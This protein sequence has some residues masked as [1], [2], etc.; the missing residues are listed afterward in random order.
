MFAPV[1]LYKFSA[2]AGR[3]W[4]RTNLSAPVDFESHTYAPSPIARQALVADGGEISPLFEVTLP[5]DD[6]LVQQ[7]LVYLPL[8]PL[9]LV[10]YRREQAEGPFIPVFIGSVASTNFDDGDATLACRPFGESLLLKVPSQTYQAPCNW[11]VY[12]FGCGI[13]RE[14]F[15][16]DSPITISA[17]GITVTGPA[18]GDKP[19]D[20]FRAGMI[21]LPNG[22]TRFITAHT[23]TSVILQNRFYD[24]PAGTVAALY[25]GCDRL[26]LTCHNKFN[27]RARFRGFDN[28]P[29]KNP[30]SDNIFGTGG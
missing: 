6:P 5:D 28:I 14:A 29:S 7:F 3:E 15:R 13:N 23:G 4:F 19:D 18:I 27:N 16:V 12:S 17:D 22:D 8:K 9:G 26:F 11:V 25:P 30:Y 10:I 21:V 2:G 20:W 24:V 1:E